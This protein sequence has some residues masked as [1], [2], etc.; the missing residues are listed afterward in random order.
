MRIVYLLLHDFRFASLGFREFAFN[1]FHFAKEYARRMA[2]RGHE[3]RLYVLGGTKQEKEVLSMDG[4]QLKSFRTSFLFP[5]KLKFGN[6]HS[7]EALRELDRD[8]PD[9]VHV[10]NYYLWNFPYVALWVKRK[11]TPLV[12]QFHGSDPIRLLKA[13]CYYPS[14]R[15]CDRILVPTPSEEH[16]LTGRLGI[17][18]GRVQRFPSTGV[19]TDRFRPTGERSEGLVLLYAGRVP[20]H[21][22]YRWEK[23]PMR[24]LPIV[25]ALCRRGLNPRLVVAGDGP[26]LEALREATRRFGMSSS[27]EF[28]G[29]VDQ[30]RLPRLYTGSTLSFVPIEI[31]E[32]GPFWGGALQE[33]L[34]C[35]TPVIGFN[36]RTPGVQNFGLLVPREPE[37]AAQMISEAA[38]NQ[39]WLSSVEEE[40]PRLVKQN[41]EWGGLAERLDSI[42]AQLRSRP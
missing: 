32:I 9:L 29:Q 12:A 27:V 6:A 33:S 38:A 24:L 7:I 15:L 10:H 36:D 25:K 20:A 39:A 8:S 16:L 18:G 28:V 21:G 35:G 41:C 17:R 26:G 22:D 1:R 19:D 23:A 37:E 5:P 13:G 11:G 42:Y 40:G 3:V 31:E 30:G 34:A 4:Y 2:L 14:L